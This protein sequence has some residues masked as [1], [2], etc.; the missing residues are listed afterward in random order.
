MASD[1]LCQTTVNVTGNCLVGGI[2]G[3]NANTGTIEKR[4]LNN[5]TITGNGDNFVEVLLVRLILRAILK[6]F[7]YLS[8]VF[9]L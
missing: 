4:Q 6:I 7:M 2:V 8:V 9:L 1:G 3:D 5:S